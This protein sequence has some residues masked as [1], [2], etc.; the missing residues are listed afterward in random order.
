M[1]KDLL[2]VSDL[3]RKE[4]EQLIE[5]ALRMKK[6]GVP[7]LLSGRTLALLFEKPS[8]RTRVSFEIAMYQLGGHSIYLSPEEVGLGK[9]EPVADVAQVLSRYVDGIAARTFSQGTLRI[10]AGHSSVPVINA[11]S[12]LEHPCQ[13]LSDLLTIYEKKGRLQGLNLAFIG[14]SNNVANSLLLAACLL[15][16]N[17]HIASPPG[18]EIKGDVLSQG[19]EF[20]ALSGSRIQL[21][22]D[23]YEAAEDADIVYTDVWA[24]MGQ[25]AEVEQ[26]SLAFSG[27]Q[28]DNKLLSLAKGD[29]L[30]MHP[31]PAHHG[32]EISVGLLDDPRSVVFDQAENRLHLQKALLARILLPNPKVLDK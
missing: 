29:V 24:S 28:V 1:K 3:D 30:F 27:Y 23:P 22:S 5:Q 9:R 31:L 2:S 32:E 12:D 25:E 8:L 18:Y 7:P 17:F 19:R 15:G 4:I 26:R 10:L 11:L 16:M 21:T 13:A 6:E 14:D 20:A